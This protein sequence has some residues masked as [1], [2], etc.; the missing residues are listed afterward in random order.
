VAPKG[1]GGIH[2]SLHATC[3]LV[4]CIRMPNCIIV[5]FKRFCLRH[6]IKE[7]IQFM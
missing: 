4:E 6:Q 1:R 3:I 2:N 7:L 5:S